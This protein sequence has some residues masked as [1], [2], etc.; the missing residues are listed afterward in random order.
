M[1]F[2]LTFLLSACSALGQA[3]LNVER[4][5][6]DVVLFIT[7]GT[8]NVQYQIWTTP[9]PDQNVAATNWYYWRHAYSST[10]HPYA[11]MI[12]YGENTS[13]QPLRFFQIRGIVEPTTIVPKK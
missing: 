8:S 10:Y 2:W 13:K 7:G 5:G 9:N 12:I 3:T 4:R 11:E 6:S 1:S